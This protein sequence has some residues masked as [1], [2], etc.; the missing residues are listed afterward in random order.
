MR[1]V[2]LT[3][4]WSWSHLIA[5]WRAT[6]YLALRSSKFGTRQSSR[7]CQR[8]QQMKGA[9]KQQPCTASGRAA[10]AAAAGTRPHSHHVLQLTTPCLG[11]QA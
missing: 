7:A 3:G 5:S 4:C 10:A 1:V 2:E 11:E 6:Q 8:H 9:E